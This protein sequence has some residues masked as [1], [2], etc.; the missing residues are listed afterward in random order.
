MWTKNRNKPKIN[1]KLDDGKI[2]NEKNFFMDDWI[3]MDECGLKI[4]E[5]FVINTYTVTL[6]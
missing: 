6:Y 5:C 3:W 4:W 2:L 1:L